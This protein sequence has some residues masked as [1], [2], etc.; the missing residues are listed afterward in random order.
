MKLTLVIIAFIPGVAFAQPLPDKPQRAAGEKQIDRLLEAE[1]PYIAKGRATYP[2]A[3]KRYLAGLPRGN[4][5]TVRKHLA[6]PGGQ[7]NEEVFV[8][9]DSIKG[10]KVYGRIASEL[11]AVRSYRKGQRISFPESEVL[12]WTI[13]H[14]DGSEE[15]NYVG[16]F[17]DTYNPR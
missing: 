16:K 12:D 6:D 4:T 17:I 9:V 13:I 11:E 14:P 5:F 2:A 3:K 15:G 7:R 1:K 10:G 8:Y